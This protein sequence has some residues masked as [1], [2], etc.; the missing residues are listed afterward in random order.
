MRVLFLYGA[1]GSNLISVQFKWKGPALLTRLTLAPWPSSTFPQLT[2][3]SPPL[4][5]SPRLAPAPAH[6]RPRPAGA[7]KTLPA[8][9]QPA[10]FLARLVAS[11]PPRPPL[12]AAGRDLSW[13]DREGRE[14]LT[15][16]TPTKVVTFSSP[17]PAPGPPDLNSNF[18]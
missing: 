3:C 18:R 4:R 8:R 16:H 14:A 15:R 2:F 5:P 13:S 9:P 11:R 7:P 6:F 10:R 1:S 17:K 12:P